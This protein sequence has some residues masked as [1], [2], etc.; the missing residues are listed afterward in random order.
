MA[1]NPT[2]P[3]GGAA[4]LPGYAELLAEARER[5]LAL[6]E[7]L[8][9]HDLERQHSP[10][11]SPLVWDLG[12]I[13]AFEDLWVCER[14]ALEPLRPELADVYDA[15]LT[16][17]ARRSAIPLLRA[18]E[19]HDY[20]DAVRER[21]LGVLDEI[22]ELH[23][24]MLVQ[25][26]SQHGETM[27]QALKLAEPGVYAPARRP[28]PAARAAA[29]GM[30]RIEAGPFRM[31]DA[32]AGFAYDNERPSHEVHLEAFEIDRVPVTNGDFRAFIEDGGYARRELWSD[33][34]WAWRGA[35][36][37]E[38]PLYWGA[39]GTLRDFERTVAVDPA[40]PVMHVCA[41][42]ADAFAR[43][44]GC[45]LPTEAEWEKAAAGAR[46]GNVDQLGFGPAAAGAYPECA[47]EH[48]VSGLLGDTWEWTASSFRGYPGFRA[49]PYPEYS[50]IF[51]GDGYR[52]LRGAAWATRPRV[53]RI[54]FR[55]WDHP[56]RRQI[57]AGF[58]C[59]REAT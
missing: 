19:V 42:E 33:A 28:L 47:S 35:E 51:F 2:S 7:P 16:P 45:R 32:G 21:T 53:A 43:W 44:R 56:Q 23:L 52:V 39:E 37:A 50:E 29:G 59:A 30:V 48:G 9:R 5:T 58:R 36:G 8:G 40:L 13:A 20:M 25:H 26:E 34:G 4:V 31:G 6:V 57:F 11:L 18:G 15:T 38:R 54:T 49:F 46:P 14:T 17:R 10:L 12:H 55:N 24:E 1:S 27:L 41:H 22:G 3:P